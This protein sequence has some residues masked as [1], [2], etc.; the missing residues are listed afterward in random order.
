MTTDDMRTQLEDI[1]VRLSTLTSLC[2]HLANA[3]EREGADTANLSD[4]FHHI[5]ESVQ[6]EEHVIARVLQ[7]SCAAAVAA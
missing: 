4:V 6:R 7:E 1:S 5:A 2:L 3:H